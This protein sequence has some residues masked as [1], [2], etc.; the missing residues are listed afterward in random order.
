[1]STT[2][3]PSGLKIVGAYNDATWATTY[4]ANFLLLNNTLLKLSALMDVTKTDIA[5]GKILLYRT[6]TGKWTPTTPKDK[7]KATGKLLK[8]T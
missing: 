8:F 1:M 4:N 6:A 2:L 7:I 3:S 5:D